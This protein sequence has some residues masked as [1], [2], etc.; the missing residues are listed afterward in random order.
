MATRTSVFFSGLWRITVH[1]VLLVALF[2]FL[3]TAHAE[4][5]LDKIKRTGKLVVA[6]EAAL[7]PFE[8]IEDGKIVG[9][10]K[11]ILDFIV[12]D[13]RTELGHLEVQQF[14]LPWQ[15]ILPGMDAGKFDFTAT[16]VTIT[17]ERAAKYAFLMPIADG[18]YYAIK[19]KGD[20]S[21]KSIEDLRGKTVGV[22][23]GSR[24]EELAT[25][26]ERKLKEGGQPGFKELKKYIGYPE[27]Y[28]GLANGETDAVL[29]GLPQLLV[30]M[31][32]R[33]NTYEL[34]GPMTAKAYITWV[35]RSTDLKLREY[36]NSKI[37][38]MKDT[39]VLS[40][41]QEK[42]FGYKMELPDSGYLPPGAI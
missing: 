41:L 28:L 4:D 36:L 25:A 27:V 37:K 8:F 30:L 16:S 35:T 15:G 17:P 32:S 33:P 14:D 10:G 19:R 2:A 11:D 38:K 5:T 13:L 24:G 39:G 42:W 34:V 31:K 9:Y 29:H 18:T 12:A 26:F 1:S 22:Q 3:G 40:K 6:T 23:L 20:A 7:K 21:I